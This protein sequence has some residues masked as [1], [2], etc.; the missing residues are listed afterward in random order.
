[1]SGNQLIIELTRMVN[2]ITS[3][4]WGRLRLAVTEAE[5]E[6]IKD[7]IQ[8]NADDPD[9]FL[10]VHALKDVPLQV[11]EYPTNPMYCIEV[12][13]SRRRAPAA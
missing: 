11:E 13:S 6:Q 4:H 2:A 5:L 8:A 9:R 12:I 1:M 7:S 3:P 10:F